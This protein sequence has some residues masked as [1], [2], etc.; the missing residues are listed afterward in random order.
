[1][2]FSSV[3]IDFTK[4]FDAINRKAQW[5]VHERIGCLRI[6]VKILQLFHD[7]IIGQ[8]L[9]GGDATGRFKSVM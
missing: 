6:F 4:A 3:F 7:G 5:T 1:M 2:P 9:T 8:V